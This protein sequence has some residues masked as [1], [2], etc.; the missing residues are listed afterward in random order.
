[1]SHKTRRRKSRRHIHNKRRISRRRVMR[2][3]GTF[4]GKRYEELTEEEKDSI[5]RAEIAQGYY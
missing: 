1:M 3:E 2:V 5:K 4:A